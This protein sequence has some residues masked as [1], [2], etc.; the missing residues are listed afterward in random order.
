MAHAV[1]EPAIASKHR[2]AVRLK[3]RTSACSAA[4]ALV[5]ACLQQH[6]PDTRGYSPEAPHA[7]SDDHRHATATPLA[8]GRRQAAAP[9]R[10]ARS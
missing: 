10:T 1:E 2:L 3:R 7:R 9:S 6:R 8:L 5:H 4:T